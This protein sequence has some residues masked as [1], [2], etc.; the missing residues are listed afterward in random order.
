MFHLPCKEKSGKQD[1]ENEAPAI[2][3]ALKEATR[4]PALASTMH[5]QLNEAC[6][7]EGQASAYTAT[8]NCCRKLY[9]VTGTY[10]EWASF[11]R[12]EPVG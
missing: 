7:T 4:D 3:I 5:R 12:M 10:A 2:E 1:L 11:F 6:I 8:V 9:R